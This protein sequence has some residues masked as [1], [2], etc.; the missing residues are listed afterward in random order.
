MQHKSHLS[1]VRM[2]VMTGRSYF[3]ISFHFIY[4]LYNNQ[5][6]MSASGGIIKM[7][8]TEGKLLKDEHQSRV[9]PGFIV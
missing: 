5:W 9:Q 6:L 7:R 4:L 1:E 2:N 3:S 8:M